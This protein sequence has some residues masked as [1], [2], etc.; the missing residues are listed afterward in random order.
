MSTSQKRK[1][2]ELTPPINEVQKR[3]T[4]DEEELI[5]N[6]KFYLLEN[7]TTELENEQPP[8]QDSQQTPKKRRI[9]PIFI[10]NANNYQEIV[11][12]LKRLTKCDFTTNY[13]QKNIKV[14]LENED[15]YR[16][17]TKFYETHK[18]EFHTFQNPNNR[19][20]SVVIRNIPVSLSE[21]EVHEELRSTNLPIIKITRLLNK[22]KRPIPLCV[23]ELTACEEATEIYKLRHIC[24]A[25]VT[26]EPRKK[27]TNIPQCH[28]CQRY[29]HTKNYC[30]LKERC[31]KCTEDHPPNQC[32]K[33]VKE[34]PTCVNCGEAHPANY[35][36][37]KVHKE[38]QQHR[39]QS[40]ET[41]QSNN[42]PNR[43]TS[44]KPKPSSFRSHNMSYAQ[45]TVNQNENQTPTNNT[46]IP[47]QASIL[48]NI[49]E[50]IKQIITPYLPQIK[51]FIINQLL[52]NLLHG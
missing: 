40:R 44:Y 51:N 50:F 37:C 3:Y 4:W 11:N 10:H 8:T 32:R 17:V 12:D 23:V 16:N 7:N 39:P 46:E 43:S 45:V 33:T 52:P 21:T 31:V 47:V 49:F 15:D 41:D 34:P 30:A 29:G 27:A 20:L 19:P 25:L 5:R 18:I 9:P 24:K 28:R 1:A 38:I 35:R 2:S 6:N 14:N 22:E 13:T 48:D 26:V 42:Q 36:G